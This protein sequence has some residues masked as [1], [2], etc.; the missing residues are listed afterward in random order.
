MKRINLSLWA[1]IL[2]FAVSACNDSENIGS[3][4]LNQD[5][6]LYATFTDTLTV[7]AKVLRTGP[8]DLAT[9][10]AD[11]TFVLGKVDD[12]VFG[13]STAS[14]CM[15]F[16]L[17]TGV[18]N[19][20]FDSLPEL[21][22]IVLSLAIKPG[23]VYGDANKDVLQSFKIYELLDSLASEDAMDV[24]IQYQTDYDCNYGD[25]L[26]ESSL[27]F[28]RDSIMVNDSTNAYPSTMSMRLEDE[29]GQRFLD[30]SAKTIE[31]VSGD[32]IVLVSS[33]FNVVTFLDFFK[34][35]VII[36]DE[37]NSAIAAFNLG[38]FNSNLKV[39]YKAW[40]SPQP[41]SLAYDNR[42][43]TF[44]VRTLASTG[45]TSPV[46][47]INSFTHDYTGTV[48]QPIL[49]SADPYVDE[50][51]YLQAM[52]GLKVEFEF[53]TF[54]NLGDVLINQAELILYDV[55]EI[56]EMFP[57]PPSL[58]FALR[59][60]TGSPLFNVQSFE[61]IDTT[62]DKNISKYTVPLTL[63]LQDYLLS[64]EDKEFSARLYEIPLNPY[65]SILTGPEHP[66]YPA[67]INVYYTEIE[68]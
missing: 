32:T 55:T 35:V 21:D 40:Y 66:E 43:N 9:P 26:G 6:L 30:A 34:G 48:I 59:D 52:A 45:L 8:L 22:S 1:L 16:A 54:L 33:F 42:V 19:L 56:D 25:L 14:M 37:N 58:S 28:N 47:A 68:Q 53:P 67:K 4:I 64:P 3:S 44:V 10:Q 41:D 62:I 13:E 18:N 15:Q 57:K 23:I 36:P 31:I 11:N 5:D 12:P 61:T 2:L 63:S 27:S 29:L 50:I 38:S 51:A 24:A 49:D 65:R 46:V 60:D 17:G 7:K 20:S 39:Y